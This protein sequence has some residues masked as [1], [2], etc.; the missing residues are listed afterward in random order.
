MKHSLLLHGCGV[1]RNLAGARNHYG[2]A[3]HDSN[4]MVMSWRD[5]KVLTASTEIEV[6]SIFKFASLSLL[7]D[8]VVLSTKKVG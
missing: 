4:W 8:E 7:E 6:T 3:S 5:L 1:S 2:R